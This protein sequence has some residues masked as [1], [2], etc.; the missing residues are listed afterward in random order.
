MDSLSRGTVARGEG[1]VGDKCIYCPYPVS[2]KDLWSVPTHVACEDEASYQRQLDKQPGGKSITGTRIQKAEFCKRCG[3][4]DTESKRR[5]HGQ[6][7]SRTC[8]ACEK[9]TGTTPKFRQPFQ[10]T[11]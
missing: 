10:E 5:K 11:L 2:E 4:S 1:Q 8:I 9:E 3:K 7:L 6:G